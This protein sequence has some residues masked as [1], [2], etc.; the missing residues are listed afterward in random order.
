MKAERV[1]IDSNV[2]IAA[3]LSPAGTAR[4]VVDTVLDR[5]IDVL[6]SE[7]VFAE[8]VSRLERPKFD[9]YREVDAWNQFLSELVEL[10]IWHEDTGVAAGVSC[11]AD[12]D[13]FLALAAI[14]RADAIISGDRDLLD[15][16]SYDGIPIL[17]P[18]QFLQ[19][20]RD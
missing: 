18:A 3:L 14:G 16:G 11:D 20:I 10:A 6:L 15:L 2:L 17:A 7:A 1:V 19:D 4:R 8:L 5:E 13:K 12:D 9:R